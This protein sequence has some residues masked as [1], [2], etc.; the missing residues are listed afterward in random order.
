MSYHD[1]DNLFNYHLVSN[2][3]MCSYLAALEMF[4]VLSFPRLLSLTFIIEFV[5]KKDDQICPQ[6]WDFSKC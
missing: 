3:P 1:I 6:N 4:G 2:L 5:I